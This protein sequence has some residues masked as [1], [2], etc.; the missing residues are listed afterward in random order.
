M[1]NTTKS[2]RATLAKALEKAMAGEL[3]SED[4]RNIIGLANQIQNSMSAEV[5]VM[6]I[7]LKT[8]QKVD[9][10]GNLNVA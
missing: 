4:G 3:S 5:K 9:D 6:T 8:G 7:K 10:F 2:I 1:G